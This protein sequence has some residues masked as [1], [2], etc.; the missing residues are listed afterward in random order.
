MALQDFAV[1]QLAE[2]LRLQDETMVYCEVQAG[3]PKNRRYMQELD[4]VRLGMQTSPEYYF[5]DNGTF[6]NFQ[7]VDLNAVEF[8][9]AA[10]TAEAGVYDVVTDGVTGALTELLDL[11]QAAA[12]GVPARRLA[13][14]VNPDLIETVEIST[15]A[16]GFDVIHLGLKSSNKPDFTFVE[17]SQPVGQWRFHDN[18]V[19]TDAGGN[20]A[21]YRG[22]NNYVL[23]AAAM[24]AV[25]TAVLALV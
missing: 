6:T 19:I 18:E 17:E 11:T 24:L 2:D 8:T 9:M 15:D 1:E 16:G 20:A 3:G 22:D 13:L 7:W 14:A 4:R 25:R 10:G 5:Y 23:N 12:G 21:A